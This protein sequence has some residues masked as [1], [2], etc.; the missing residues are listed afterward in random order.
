MSTMEG[1]IAPVARGQLRL[2]PPIP[3]G[4]PYQPRNDGQPSQSP[5][6]ICILDSSFNPPT[7]AHLTLASSGFPQ[8][9]SAA[10]SPSAPTDGFA[11]GQY[12][13]RLLL[14]STSNVEKTPSP[15]DPTLEQR[16]RLISLLASHMGKTG[17]PVA[18]GLIN[19]PT[20]IGKSKI[21]HSFLSPAS[22]STPN[23]RP[24]LSFIVG[25]DTLTRC[26]DPRFYGA[27]PG[28][29]AQA[30]SEFFEVEG[31]TLVCGRRKGE[32]EVE[33]ALMKRDEVRERVDQGHVRLFGTGEEDWAGIS[34]TQV[35]KAVKAQ[36]WER[37]RSMVIPEI[38]DCIKEAGLYSS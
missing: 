33:D 17:E 9:S 12:T 29:M 26:F 23:A 2:I 11:N 4:W 14:F 35:R 20:F 24:R 27:V 37:A 6:H 34:S 10:T 32:S 25:T 15:G 18:V 19:E 1:S 36:D 5:L 28:G 13:A 38:A 30:L 31:S 8:V 22:I 21:I 3:P 7:R 16:V